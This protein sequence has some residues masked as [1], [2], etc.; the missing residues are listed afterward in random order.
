M[1]VNVGFLTIGIIDL[2]LCSCLHQLVLLAGEKQH[3]DKDG[4]CVKDPNNG[5]C[6]NLVDGRNIQRILRSKKKNSKDVFWF[7]KQ[8]CRSFDFFLVKFV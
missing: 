7:W 2:F 1:H 3:C 6:D 8:M 4:E 5:K